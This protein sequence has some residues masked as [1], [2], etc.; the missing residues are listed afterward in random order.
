MKILDDLSFHLREAFIGLRQAKTLA[1]ATVASI[2]VSLFVLGAFLV[3]FNKA[4]TALAKLKGQYKL[5]IYV[6]DT[7]GEEE[8]ADLKGRLGSDAAVAGFTYITKDEALQ[9]M[10]EELGEKAWVLK[11]LETNPLP[12]AVEVT[13]Q[14]DVPAGEFVKRCELYPAVSRISSG[15][16]WV[17]GLQRFVT[18][19]RFLGLVVIM[20][21][22]SAALLIVA[23]TIWLTIYA[24]RDEI[25]IM[26]LVGATNWYIRAPFLVEGVLAGL[27]GALA[28]SLAL[29]FSYQFLVGQVGDVAPRIISFSPF[30]E[31][32][33]VVAQLMILGTLLGLLGSLLSLR[34]IR[35]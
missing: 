18:M 35:P 33:R 3:F 13:L 11:T 2:G 19:C 23:N 4:E 6:K 5:V 14:E 20:V 12:D 24:R 29:F 27:G 16:E 1:L 15:Q 10:L 30:L 25:S 26:Q 34:R 8:V 28:A 21:L 22:G 7:A 32:Q 9:T 17:D 31:L